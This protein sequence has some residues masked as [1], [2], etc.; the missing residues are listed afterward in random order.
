MFR[1]IVSSYWNFLDYKQW[2]HN[3]TH[4]WDSHWAYPTSST[5]NWDDVHVHNN[6]PICRS[7]VPRL[8]RSGPV[9]SWVL[10][11]CPERRWLWTPRLLKSFRKWT[12]KPRAK[13]DPEKACCFPLRSEGAEIT[14]TYSNSVQSKL[15][16]N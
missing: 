14:L 3:K 11:L 13:C 4:F 5:Y 15:E 10:P 8:L 7:T 12:R 1:P 6:C 16:L 2:H 9:E